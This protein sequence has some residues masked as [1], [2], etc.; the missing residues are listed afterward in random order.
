MKETINKNLK[1]A[2]KTIDNLKKRKLYFILPSLMDFLFLFICGI[3]LINALAILEPIIEKN[4]A[5][6]Q[7]IPEI[8]A[9]ESAMLAYYENQIEYGAQIIAVFSLFAIAAFVLWLIF[10]GINW[11]LASKLIRNKVRKL[12]FFFNFFV[13]SLIGFIFMVIIGIF[14]LDSSVKIRMGLYNLMP[15]LGINIFSIVFLFLVCYFAS[16]GYAISSKYNILG[17]LKNIFIIGIKR[18]KDLMVYW[19]VFIILLFA[20]NY[21]I[22]PLV[23]WLVLLIPMPE[24]IGWIIYLLIGC[25][26]V[27]PIF[28]FARV[29]LINIIEKE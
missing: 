4:A 26:M 14:Y 6:R 21:L 2:S 8:G 18:A 11:W 20:L 16:I 17:V 28:A 3:V 12:N 13:V 10:Q 7:N 15:L 24:L 22:L 27:F 29:Y 19:F 1:L 25:M 9:D 5:E 23:G